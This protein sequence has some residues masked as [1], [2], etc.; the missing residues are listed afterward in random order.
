MSN[1]ILY[2]FCVSLVIIS[3][4]AQSGTHKAL[5][6][7]SRLLKPLDKPFQNRP[8][9]NPSETPFLPRDFDHQFLNP[10]K[11]KKQKKK[12]EKKKKH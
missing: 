1:I 2:F 7:L 8:P 5:N 6:L 12:N 3:V 11:R 10:P 9:G 4:S